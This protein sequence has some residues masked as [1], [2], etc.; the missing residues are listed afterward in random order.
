MSKSKKKTQK[1]NPSIPVF[2]EISP[3]RHNV[4][5]A[6]FHCQLILPVFGKIVFE[7]KVVNLNIKWMLE[8]EMG[9]VIA[10]SWTMSEMIF[11]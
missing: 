9:F 6:I 8:S 11:V 1:R 10:I 7:K 3:T 2:E 4:P 5:P